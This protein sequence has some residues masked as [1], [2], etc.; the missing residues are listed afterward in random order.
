MTFCSDNTPESQLLFITETCWENST[1]LIGIYIYI[2]RKRKRQRKITVNKKQ[3]NII[4][5]VYKI[6]D[7]SKF[8]F[9]NKLIF[10]L[11]SF[12]TNCKLI[13]CCEVRIEI[14]LHS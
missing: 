10:I 4:Y 8:I 14:S 11:P 9:K 13:K 5:N 2:Y 6:Y 3:I 12:V 1:Y 7:L